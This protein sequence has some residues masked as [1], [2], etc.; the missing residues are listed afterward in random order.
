MTSGAG[1]QSWDP[2]AVPGLAPPPPAGRSG[3]S[4]GVADL[5][6]HPAPDT[7]AAEWISDLSF[8]ELV[9]FGPAGFEA[10]A[11]LRFIPDP[12]REGQSE[13]D[14]VLPA[15]HPSELDQSRRA[16]DQLARH[17]ETADQCYFCIWD[18]YGL[19]LVAGPAGRAV[20]H[21]PHRSYALMEGPLEA[22]E[23]WEADLGRE[24]PLVPPAL[25]WP[26][27]HSWCFVSDVDPHW[28][29]IGASTAA[30]GQLLADP[31]LDIVAANPR[32]P[33]PYYY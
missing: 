7:S 1:H 12:R 20:L 5:G 27:D 13:A 26:A 16:L 2:C 19:D 11:R 24:G 3:H 29:G 28:A 25:V 21:L 14:V 9:T 10:Y 32:D 31:T 33:Q 22:L 17:T 4:P 8:D 23:T 15:D 6:L 18:G 30:I